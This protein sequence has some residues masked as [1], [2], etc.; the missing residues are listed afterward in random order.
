MADEKVH[1]PDYPGKERERI[2]VNRI[3][4]TTTNPFV[5]FQGVREL[6][7][8]FQG[9]SD[10]SKITLPWAVVGLRLPFRHV[11]DDWEEGDIDVLL[12]PIEPREFVKHIQGERF[13]PSLDYMEAIE[14]K[15]SLLNRE[16]N[17]KSPLGFNVKGQW[18]QRKKQK[19]ARESAL[20]LC[21]A[22][23]DQVAVLDI[24][25]TEPKENFSRGSI[26]W[27]IAGEDAYKARRKLEPQI[28]FEDTDPFGTILLTLG[29]VPAHRED[30]AG[31]GPS[32]LIKKTPP[33]N[34][35][36]AQGIR[37]RKALEG[38]LQEIFSRGLEKLNPPVLVL[39]CSKC[40][41]IYISKVGPDAYCPV[42]NSKPC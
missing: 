1:I 35:L 20:K 19:N 25:S 23:F 31:S 34:P 39:A 32:L 13:A 26:S 28:H 16:N 11:V 2:A 36:K 37:F 27:F 15:Y 42:C 5:E 9:W 3:F 10:V 14:V 21:R 33:P 24:V 18:K 7:P 22:G 17:L 38:R 8:G 41:N 6:F 40:P 4:T 30:T 12:I 29:A